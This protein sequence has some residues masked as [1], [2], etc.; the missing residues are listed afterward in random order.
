MTKRLASTR[1]EME[2]NTVFTDEA[3]IERMMSWPDSEFKKIKSKVSKT[4][5]RLLKNRKSARYSRLKKKEQF[6]EFTDKISAM[7]ERLR[8]MEE[9]N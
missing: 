4:E 3:E 7:A 6:S 5:W 1:D 9:E 2:G 8:Q